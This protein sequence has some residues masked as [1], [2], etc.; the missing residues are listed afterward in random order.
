MVLKYIGENL[1]SMLILLSSGIQAADGSKNLAH[2]LIAPYA[3]E[4]S[5]HISL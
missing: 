2:L 4:N 1:Y 3:T 5:A